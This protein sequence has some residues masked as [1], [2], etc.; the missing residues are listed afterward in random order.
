MNGAFRRT[1]REDIAQMKDPVRFDIFHTYGIKCKLFLP[2]NGVIKRIILG[3]HGFAGDKESSML[4]RLAESATSEETALISFDFPTHGESTQT[5]DSLTIAN[6]VRDLLCVAEWVRE[7]YP[8]A[9]RY[10]FATSFGGYISLLCADEL[11]DFSF[12]LRAPAIN[13]PQCLLNS[14]L[15]VTRE[16]FERAKVLQCGYERK[17]DLP[18]A[19]YEGMLQHDPVNRDYQQQMLVIHG[20]CDDVVP[21]CDVALFCRNHPHV[22]FITI[23]GADHRFKKPGEIERIIDKTMRFIMS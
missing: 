18:F 23:K 15:K 16:E 5:E 14:V 7:Q 2:G 20:D 17:I 4:S 8:D 6:C 22:E 21:Y 13:M 19:F 10:I 1:L 9:G 11:Q 12:V 3:V